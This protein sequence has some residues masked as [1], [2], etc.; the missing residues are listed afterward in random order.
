MKPSPLPDDGQLWSTFEHGLDDHTVQAVLAVH[1]GQVDLDDVH[2]EVGVALLVQHVPVV[3]VES[4]QQCVG[5]RQHSGTL[6][7]QEL[8]DFLVAN[9]NS[10]FSGRS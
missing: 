9:S 4:V 6:T 8:S 7:G 2:D 5:L 3:Q 10:S 1:T